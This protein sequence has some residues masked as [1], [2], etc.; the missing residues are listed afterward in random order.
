M[1]KNQR[2]FAI[3]EL[4]MLS[5][6]AIILGLVGWSVYHKHHIAHVDNTSRQQALTSFGP[7]VASLPSLS[8]QIMW[9][10]DNTA[11]SQPSHD[12]IE[13]GPGTVTRD[14]SR[15]ATIDK[16]GPEL[17]SELETAFSNNGWADPTTVI[18]GSSSTVVGYHYITGPCQFH[19]SCTHP[20]SPSIGVDIVVITSF[21]SA[22][23]KSA[24]LSDNVKNYLGGNVS[25]LIAHF[26]TS[27]A[28]VYGYSVD[29]Q[30]YY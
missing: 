25:K 28:P 12:L 26:K 27:S 14:I 19:L 17:L 23:T 6:L 7:A 9:T 3:T 1:I 15:F 8:G 18:Q 11:D 22:D 29:A 16:T 5:I 2:G 30:S 24:P 21:T 10:Q 4:F 20:D 13:P